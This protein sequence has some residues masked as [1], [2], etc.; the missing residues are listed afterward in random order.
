MESA[1]V[2]AKQLFEAVAKMW[3]IVYTTGSLSDARIGD[4]TRKIIQG[5]A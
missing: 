2:V 5:L 4:P 3:V 1:L